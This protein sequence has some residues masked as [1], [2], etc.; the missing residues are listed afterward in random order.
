MSSKGI[1]NPNGMFLL[2]ALLSIFGDPQVISLALGVF[3]IL[4]RAGAGL[5]LMASLGWWV[6]GRYLVTIHRESTAL[7]VF[8]N[9]V[10]FKYKR[11]ILNEIVHV[12]SSRP[13]GEVQTKREIPLFFHFTHSAGS[14]TLGSGTLVFELSTEIYRYALDRTWDLQSRGERLFNLRSVE[15]SCRDQHYFMILGYHNSEFP[16]YGVLQ[17]TRS[18]GALKLGIYGCPT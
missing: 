2:G 11:E 8:E 10:A 18:R 16:R 14:P 17:E 1:P 5:L 13:T 15:E 12:A 4:G 3:Q 9:D 6:H 7:Q